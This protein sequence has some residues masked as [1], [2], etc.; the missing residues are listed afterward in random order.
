MFRVCFQSRMLQSCRFWERV[1]R[2]NSI[3]NRF[4]LFIFI[5]FKI[6]PLRCFQATQCIKLLPVS[7]VHEIILIFLGYFT[8][9]S[10]YDVLMRVI[11]LKLSFN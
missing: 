11:L 6:N 5:I 10:F 9:V 1:N 8:Y 3:F 7:A 2:F 4:R